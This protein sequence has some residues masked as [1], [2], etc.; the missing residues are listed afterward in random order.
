MCGKQTKNALNG[1]H[2]DILFT[3][4]SEACKIINSLPSELD[5]GSSLDVNISSQQSALN[6]FQRLYQ[7]LWI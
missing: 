3:V 7:I 2:V 6:F 5:K 1:Y 4:S